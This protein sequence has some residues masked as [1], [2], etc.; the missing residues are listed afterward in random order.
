LTRPTGRCSPLRGSTLWTCARRPSTSRSSEWPQ[1]SKGWHRMR[2]RTTL[3]YSSSYSL[4]KLQH[5]NSLVKILQ[6]RQ[7]LSQ[8]SSTGH[9]AQS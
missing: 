7:G 5:S 1:L 4:V 3:H 9:G 2:M 6:S 8:E